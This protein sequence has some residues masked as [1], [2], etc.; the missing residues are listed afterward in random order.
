MSAAT[1]GSEENSVK[2]ETRDG[3]DSTV[4]TDSVSDKSVEVTPV[5]TGD[6]MRKKKSVRIAPPKQWFEILFLTLMKI[7]T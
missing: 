6:V 7:L 2:A 5:S 1:Q 3:S 4:T